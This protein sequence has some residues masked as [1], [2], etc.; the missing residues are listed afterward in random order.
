MKKP[1]ASARSI[2]LE[3]EHVDDGAR[4]RLLASSLL[5][6]LPAAIETGRQTS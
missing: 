3:Q 6:H 4:F 5:Q 1:G 2:P